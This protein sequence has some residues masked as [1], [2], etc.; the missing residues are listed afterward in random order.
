M[1]RPVGPEVIAAPVDTGLR[2]IVGIA[3]YYRIAADAHQIE[4][5]LALTGRLSN[6]D[7]LIRAARLVGLKARVLRG[8]RA[9]RLLTIPTPAILRL[10]DVSFSILIARGPAGECR[11]VNPVTKFFREVPA[12]KLFEEFKPLLRL[13]ISYFETRAAGQTV[14]RVRELENIRSFLTGQALFSALDFFFAFVFIAVL[15]AYS[16]KLTLIV[17]ASIPLY[18]AIGFLVRP[19]LRE[20]VKEKFNRGAASQQ[21]LVETVVG[22]QTVKS[23]AVEP[24]MQAQWEERLAA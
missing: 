23:A 21:F 10:N 16:W 9:K 17:L 14:A 18:L 19:P 22:M 8:I 1:N 24:L 4:R 7:D 6:E 12:E 2:A 5:E 15:L 13:P 11:I 20:K 3:G